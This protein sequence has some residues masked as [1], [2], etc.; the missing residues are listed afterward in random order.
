MALCTKDQGAD[1]SEEKKSN[2]RVE[3]AGDRAKIQRR[4][5]FELGHNSVGVS[6]GCRRGAEADCC[7]EKRRYPIQERQ[8]QHI[9]RVSQMSKTDG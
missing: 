5:G 6:D 1:A 4:R 8:Q 9:C 2:F 3:R 7:G